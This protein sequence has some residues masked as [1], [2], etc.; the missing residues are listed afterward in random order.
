MLDKDFVR[1]FFRWL[2]DASN[3][4]LQKKQQELR[5]LNEI[6]QDPDVKADLRYLL[7]L[8]ESELVVR[9]LTN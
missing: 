1:T 6:I 4:A 8:L 2:E 9:R 5:N 3:D 7:R